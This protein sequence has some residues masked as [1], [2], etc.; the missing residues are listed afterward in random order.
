[1]VGIL[2]YGIIT[3]LGYFMT[4]V[5]HFFALATMIGL[6][7][8]G[9]QA[10][11]RSLYTRI[12]PNDKSAEF[13]GFY[14]MLGKFAAVIGP[15]MM[16]YI[17]IVTGNIRYGILSI[18]ILFIIGGFLLLKVNLKEGEKMAKEYLAK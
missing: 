1:M 15:F 10:L 13:F 6:F 7:Q 17:T 9:I 18:M 4:E 16:G 8:G 14:N 12:I 5:W 2:G 11:S 3:L